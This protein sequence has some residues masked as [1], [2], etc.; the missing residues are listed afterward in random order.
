MRQ[1]F[2]AVLPRLLTP[3]RLCAPCPRARGLIFLAI[4]MLALHAGEALAVCNFQTGK[5]V[6]ST[7]V[8]LPSLT[9]PRNTPVGTVVYDSN[10]QGYGVSTGISCSGV[11]WVTLG[12]NPALTAVAGMPNVYETGVPGIGIK[13]AWSNTANTAY[14]PSNIDAVGNSGAWLVA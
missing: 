12:F 11:D 6:T 9:I 13:A 7:I 2:K 4:A 1:F 8:T 5:T 10:W 14:H 3:M